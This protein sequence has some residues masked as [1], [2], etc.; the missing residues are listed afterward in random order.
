MSADLDEPYAEQQDEATP[1]RSGWARRL[2]SLTGA[3]V[4]LCVASLC[5]GLVGGWMARGTLVPDG[6]SASPGSSQGPSAAAAANR[7]PMPDVR[8]LSEA[9]A[10]QVIADAGYEASIVKTSQAPSVLAKGTVASQDPVAG[11]KDPTS[12]TLA[13]SVPATTPDLVG[14]SLEDATTALADMGAQPAVKRVYEANAQPGN[15]LRSDPQPGQPLTA[16]PTLTVAAAGSTARLTDLKSTGD[17]GS[18][19]SG[20]VNGTQI[21]DGVSCTARD[22]PRPTYWIL[23]RSLNRLKATVGLTDSSDQSAR[24]HVQITADG[25]PLL[26]RDFGYGESAPLDAD[27]SGVL[28]LDVSV[29]T[30]GGNRSTSSYNNPSAVLANAVVLGSADAVNALNGSH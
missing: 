19:S 10:R 22:E 23:G 25:R 5:L 11:T 6:S 21:T 12:I 27:I 13:L 14:K 16:A 4:I 8:G 30:V 7:L 29:S 17:C 9:D 24:A 15:V 18:T 1:R 3:V 20:T 2:L 28:R 26:D